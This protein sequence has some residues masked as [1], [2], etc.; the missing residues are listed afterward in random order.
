MLVPLDGETLE[1]ALVEVAL[2]HAAA[3]QAPAP[4]VGGAD[5]ADEPGEVVVP[6]R[7]EDQVPMV[8]HQAVGEHAHPGD[9]LASLAQQPD[10]GREVGG[11]GEDSHPAVAA[12]D[13]VVHD[14][15]RGRPSC[16][17][18]DGN[19]TASTRGPQEG[20]MSPFCW[21]PF[22]WPQRIDR[23]HGATPFEDMRYRA[24]DSAVTN[25]LSVPWH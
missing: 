15:A 20:V 17:R 4:H 5:P 3:V 14:A 2:A 6:R 10:E 24:Y 7:P 12:V 25:S 19:G 22:C 1:P 13:H 9:A 23:V 21:P 8:V 16:P 11:F 18:H